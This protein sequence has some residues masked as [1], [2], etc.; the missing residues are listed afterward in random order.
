MPLFEATVNVTMHLR[1]EALDVNGAVIRARSLGARAASMVEQSMRREA[2]ETA[3]VTF[4]LED[5]PMEIRSTAY[6]Q[7]PDG[8]ATPGQF[9]QPAGT[10]SE[11]KLPRLTSPGAL[12][13]WYSAGHM[14]LQQD[15]HPIASPTAWELE[16]FARDAAPADAWYWSVSCIYRI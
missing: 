11:F 2:G 15:Y 3:S 14:L 16:K 4:E 1:V 8:G 12:V 6:A 13:S 5:S 9:T 10:A 7:V